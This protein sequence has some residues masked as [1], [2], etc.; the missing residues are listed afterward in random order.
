MPGA[1][2]IDPDSSCLTCKDL[3]S[4]VWP[5]F[6]VREYYC[7]AI[8]CQR[9]REREEAKRKVKKNEAKR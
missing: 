9:L 5:G 3:S 2:A 1:F 8:G 4:A 7:I 6:E